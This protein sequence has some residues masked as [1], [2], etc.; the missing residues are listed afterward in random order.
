[1][2]VFSWNFSMTNFPRHAPHQNPQLPHEAELLGCPPGAMIFYGCAK[3]T[4][5]DRVYIY[6][7]VCICIYIDIYIL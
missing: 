4:C 3:V 6:I 2:T 7:C 1:M 5:A